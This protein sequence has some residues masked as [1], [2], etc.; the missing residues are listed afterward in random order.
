MTSDLV[1][2]CEA[3]LNQ[4]LVPLRRRL[5][6]RQAKYKGHTLQF[7]RSYLQY[8]PKL[9]KGLSV[10]RTL[11][12]C[13]LFF[14]VHSFADVIYL[15]NGDRI[16]GEIK[17]IWDESVSIEPAYS[18]EFDVDLDD[19]ASMETDKP[20]DIELYNGKQGDYKIVRSDNEGEIILKDDAEEIVLSLADMKRVEE[21]EDFYEW[22]ARLDMS[23]SL[24]RGNTDSFTANINGNLEMKWGDHRTL[25]TLSTIREELDGSKVKE[26]DRVNASYNWF[27]NDPW[28]FAVNLNVERD[29]IVFLDS[30]VSVNPAVGYDIFDDPDLFL[31]IQAGGGY[32]S[33]EI[34]GVTE[35]GSL[36][37]WRLRYSQDF[38][39]GDLEL[40]HNHQMYKNLSGREN[41]VFNSVTGVRYDITD[42]IYINAQLNYD[43]DSQPSDNTVSDD[44]TIL[45]GAGIEF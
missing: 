6:A 8:A 1:L 23:Q 36:L 31:S 22:E 41:L 38:F 39:N 10:K 3:G 32:Q 43:T 42:D 7:L 26:K 44:L 45:F 24:S 18:D 5:R 30:R 13:L 37:D 11:V 21:I 29:P 35:T 40:F 15:K 12:F 16:T 28:F 27:F 19:I 2:G 33:E 25:Y 17:K 20:F 14:S 34:D 9:L 4:Q